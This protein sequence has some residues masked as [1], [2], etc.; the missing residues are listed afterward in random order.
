M[1]IL[2]IALVANII[3]YIKNQWLDWNDSLIDMRN[4]Y[5]RVICTQTKHYN[6]PITFTM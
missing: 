1:Y 3:L 4:F 5:A 6:L 2:T